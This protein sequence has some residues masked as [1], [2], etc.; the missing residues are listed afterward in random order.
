[1]IGRQRRQDLDLATDGQQ[2]H[3]ILVPQVTEQALHGVDDQREACL[4]HAEAAVDRNGQRQREVGGGERLHLLAPPVLLDDEVVSRE[5]G[6]RLAAG[7]EH[8]GIHLDQADARSEL[9]RCQ[10]RER[11]QGEADTQNERP[12]AR[13]GC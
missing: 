1:M 5:T 8:A 2:R 10:W 7:I 9:P 3:A 11:T 6:H 13:P 12:K 4:R